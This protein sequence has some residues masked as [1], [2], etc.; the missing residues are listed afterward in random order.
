MEIREMKVE[1][2]N[3]ERSKIKKKY[4]LNK[5]IL[6][7]LYLTLL[8][9]VFFQDASSEFTESDHSLHDQP[10]P[11][12]SHTG[13]GSPID[14]QTPDNSEG[15]TLSSDS[16]V[17]SKN[18]SHSS[19]NS[20]ISEPNAR[21][22]ARAVSMARFALDESEDS[23]DAHD[24][25]HPPRLPHIESKIEDIRIVQQFINE[26]STATLENGGL[27]QST[28]ERLRNPIAQP[29]DI[30][31][32]DTRLSIDLYLA[33]TNASEATYRATRDAIIFRFPECEVLSWNAVKKLVA[34][35]TGISSV[36]DD[37][38]INSCHAFTGPWKDLD[39]CTIC[40]ESRYEEVL[41]PKKQVAC[42]KFTTILLGPQLQA[43]LRSVKCAESQKY[44]H[45]KTA[46][47]LEKLAVGNNMFDLE[48][49]MC[50][51]EYLKFAQNLP[52]TENDVLLS[53][54]IDGAQLYQN[55]R[56]DTWIAIWTNFN[57]PP[58]ERYKKKAVL[59]NFMIPGPH[60]PKH[61]ESFTFRALHHLSALQREDDGRGFKVWDAKDECISSCRPCLAAVTC[62]SLALVEVDGKAGHHAAYGCRASCIMKNRHKYGIGH[63]HMVHSLPNDYHVDGCM[64]PD[65][66]ICA[67]AKAIITHLILLLVQ[68][69]RMIMSKIDLLL[70]FR[71]HHFLTVFDLSAFS[72]FLGVSHLMLCILSFLILVVYC[73]H[74]GE[75]LSVA[76]LE[77]TRLPG[78]GQRLLVTTG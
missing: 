65:I 64:H 24:N 38:C 62:D 71:N 26:I 58:N 57:L 19:D 78:T 42:Q 60:K 36:E 75:G 68:L 11:G 33:N 46:E 56:S 49:I 74:F 40:G 70:V 25:Q 54:S 28:I 76:I 31:D 9:F 48:D 12:P 39:H 63:Y 47:L 23:S 1:M 50:G 22:A 55:K 45:N 29:V 3:L 72:L 59:P 20:D 21:L 52:L 32:P 15:D 67:T 77:M 61:M 43:L 30:S 8:P 73:Y 34:D 6:P 14:L 4:G 5:R 69:T 51:S 10:M 17:K 7:P 35:I 18:S 13:L 41:L 37:M 44:R 53:F 2:N 27:D 66:D 16:S